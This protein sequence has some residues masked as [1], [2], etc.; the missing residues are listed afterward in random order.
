MKS[1]KIIKLELGEF[2]VQDDVYDKL[3]IDVESIFNL[4][5]SK[6][7]QVEELYKELDLIQE[8]EHDKYDK[9][10]KE[11]DRITDNINELNLKLTDYYT[12]KENIMLNYC[13]KTDVKNDLVDWIAESK[14]LRE[15]RQDIWKD[16]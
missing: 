7:K 12:E 14:K 2:A 9:I 1:L 11:I 16:W 10:D 13:I 8:N 4:I 5:N 6:K 3:N 15:K